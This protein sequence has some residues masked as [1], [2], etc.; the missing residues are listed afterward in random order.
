MGDKPTALLKFSIKYVHV[1]IPQLPVHLYFP[2]FPGASVPGRAK[3]A[4][5]PSPPCC[6]L[7]PTPAVTQHKHVCSQLRLNNNSNDTQLF[8]GLTWSLS[9]SCKPAIVFK[10][11]RTSA[12][13][14]SK[15]LTSPLHLSS[16]EIRQHMFGDEMN[17]RADELELIS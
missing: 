9:L 10:M 14:T 15:T 12:L 8:W 16:P 6:F 3:E 7:P 11:C 1:N 4:A 5:W 2:C 13:P 17:A